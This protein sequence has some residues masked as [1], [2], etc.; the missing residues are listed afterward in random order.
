MKRYFFSVCW[1]FY[2]VL[3]DF[4]CCVL[5]RLIMMPLFFENH[6][7]SCCL[8]IG[9]K[10][11]W[12]YETLLFISAWWVFLFVFVVFVFRFFFVWFSGSVMFEHVD[13]SYS[14]L[15]Q[16][17]P[18]LLSDSEYVQIFIV[19]ALLSVCFVIGLPCAYFIMLK[20]FKNQLLKRQ[21]EEIQVYFHFPCFLFHFRFCLL[22][23]IFVLF[24]FFSGF[25]S[26]LCVRFDFILFLFFLFSVK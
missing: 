1:V 10:K 2:F 15:A 26:I 21:E 8:F 7:Q 6:R 13:V 9:D 14:V 25:L 4:G 18:C 16:W 3:F 12:N 23:F 11:V 22:F 24:I 19:A 20:K 17:I 5:L